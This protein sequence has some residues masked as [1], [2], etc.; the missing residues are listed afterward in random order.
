MAVWVLLMVVSMFVYAPVTLVLGVALFA[1]IGV[2]MIVEAVR[3]L[4]GKPF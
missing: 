4:R 3:H 2:L 1:F